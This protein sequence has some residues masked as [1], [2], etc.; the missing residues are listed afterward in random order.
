VDATGAGDVFTGTVAARLAL[1]DPLA[2]A[3]RLGIGAASLSVGGRGG[4]GYIPSLDASL[5]A[6][7]KPG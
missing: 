3:V 5:A 2:D 6:A 7:G 1:G 4:T